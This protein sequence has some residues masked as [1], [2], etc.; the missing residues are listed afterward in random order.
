MK[1][2]E[3]VV[4]FVSAIVVLTVLVAIV[5]WWVAGRKLPPEWTTSDW[6]VLVTFP[7]VIIAVASVVLA[8]HGLRQQEM[9]QQAAAQRFAT[10][11]RLREKLAEAQVMPYLDLVLCGDFR[12]T[13]GL[14]L[15]NY[16]L[17]PA[18]ITSWQKQFRKGGKVAMTLRG[19]LEG[20][21]A[22][23]KW[24]EEWKEDVPMHLRPGESRCF[25]QI[26]LAGLEREGLQ[27]DRA[28]AL[29]DNLADQIKDIGLHLEYRNALNSRTVQ[30]I[31]PSAPH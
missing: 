6:Q 27:P 5:S 7:T 14:L 31:N 8:W 10:E 19:V 12:T 24:D 4:P 21:L 22:H 15:C 1:A 30:D 23:L 9:A 29:M 13:A 2:R 17:G 11:T 26:S 20:P 28:Q 3:Y 25:M 18:F 16:G